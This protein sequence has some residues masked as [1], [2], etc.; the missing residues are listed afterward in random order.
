[1]DAIAG[2]GTKKKKNIKMK[3]RSEI[4]HEGLAGKNTVGGGGRG[5]AGRKEILDPRPKAVDRPYRGQR[6]GLF[7]KKGTGSIRGQRGV[8]GGGGGECGSRTS[9]YKRPC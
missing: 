9:R 1:M 3:F 7:R 8:G 5:G 6:L 4:E 2:W